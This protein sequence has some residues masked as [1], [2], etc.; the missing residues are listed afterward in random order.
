MRL[1]GSSN[2]DEHRNIKNFA[3]CIL[4]IWDGDRNANES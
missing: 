4:S 1:C 3:D 2:P